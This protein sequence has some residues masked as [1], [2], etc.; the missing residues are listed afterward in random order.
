MKTGTTDDSRDAWTIGY[1]PQIVVGVWVGNNDNTVMA[2]G[3]SGMAG[4]I[5]R[6]TLEGILQG[7][8]SVAFAK[9]SSVE[10]LLICANG[11]RATKQGPGVFADFFIIGTGPTKTCEVQDEP[12][13]ETPANT[14]DDSDTTDEE[15]PDTTDGTTP[16]DTDTPTD[17]TPDD[18]TDPVDPLPDTPVTPEGQQ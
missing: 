9:P 2:A 1:T 6:N 13:T 15:T 17:D 18:G 14:T 5:W 8:P 11:L 7:V 3:G 10:Q 4:P 16:D 12:K